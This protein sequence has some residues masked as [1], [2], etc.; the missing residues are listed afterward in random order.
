MYAAVFCYVDYCAVV[1]SPSRYLDIR[2]ER[3]KLDVIDDPC[4]QVLFST[5]EFQCFV[6]VTRSSSPSAS[7]AASF[8]GSERNVALQSPGRPRPQRPLDRAG[9]APHVQLLQGGGPRRRDA[10]DPH[11]HRQG[12]RC[13]SIPPAALVMLTELNELFGSLKSEVSV[14]SR[15]IGWRYGGTQPKVLI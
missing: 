14:Y 12:L 5:A 9:R 11:Q 15:M 10:G 1:K 4:D 7:G 3:L 2:V 8:R 6:A 13:V